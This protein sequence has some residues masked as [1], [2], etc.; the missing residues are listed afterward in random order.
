MA[1]RNMVDRA[2]AQ[3]EII[4]VVDRNDPYK[5]E[6]LALATFYSGTLIHSD[7]QSL[8]EKIIVTAA[9]LI[10]MAVRIWAVDGETVVHYIQ[11]KTE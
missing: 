3:I 7:G 5:D 11:F 2:N 10:N 9:L 1:H 8:P 4:K 6:T